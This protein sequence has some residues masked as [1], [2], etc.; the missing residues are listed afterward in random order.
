VAANSAACRIFVSKSQL[1]IKMLNNTFMHVPGI[2]LKTER[3][4]WDAGILSW[5]DLG[6]I[7]RSDLPGG[8]VR[9][10][11]E[12]CRLPE[13]GYAKARIF[14]DLLPPSQYWRLF[15]HFRHATAYLDIETSGGTGWEEEITAISLWDGENLYHYV[16]GENLE[17]F[18]GAISD[19]QVIVTYNGKCFDVPVIERAFGIRLPQAHIDLRFLL[20]R[21]GYKGGLKGCERQFGLDRGELAG[22][23]GYF[24]VLLWQEYRRT[25]NPR[26]RETLLAYNAEDTIN[27]ETLMVQAY[28]L[29]I[30]GTPFAESHR[31]PLPARPASPFQ[32]DPGLIGKLR[33]RLQWKGS[34]SF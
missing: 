16:Q 12:H 1:I 22:V 26:A 3:R 6:E 13:D 28:N 17:A 19:Y 9:L 33:E 10:L 2:G 14:A 4:L 32:A 25:G 21:L 24:A 18:A 11:R 27:L 29:N 31:L 15:P 23:D 34:R 5:E 8:K 7:G 30:A 20:H